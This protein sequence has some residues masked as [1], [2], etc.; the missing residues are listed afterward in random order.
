MLLEKNNNFQGYIVSSLIKAGDYAESYRVKDSTG[1]NYFLKIVDFR[2]IHPSQLD[3]EG[4]LVEEY[5]SKS[6]N[7]K[8]LSTYKE[9]GSIFINDTQHTYIIYEYIIGETLAEKVTRAQRCSVYD[10]KRYAL[11]ILEG[12]KYLHSQDIPIIHN[13]I[14]IQNTMLNLN[15]EPDYAMLIDFGHARMLKSGMRLA[16]WDDLNPFYLAPERF[17][18]ICSVSTDLYSVGVLMYHLLFGRTPWYFDISRYDTEDEVVNE[19]LRRKKHPFKMPETKDFF[20]FDEQ[21]TNIIVRATSN[22]INE[23]FQTATEFIDAI[24]G[25]IEVSRP[26]SIVESIV[27][28][29]TGRNIKKGNGFKDVAGMQ[30]LKDQLKSDVID[31]LNHPDEAKALGINLPNG[32]LFYGPPGCGKTFFAEKFAEE[33]GMNYIYVKCSDVASPYIHGGQ[34][35]I[36]ALFD[37]AREK[38]PT[39]IFLDEID[40]MI[41]DRSK[42]N[43]ASEAGEVN[44][45]LTQLN[46]CGKDKVLVIGATNKPSELDEAALRSGRL[47]LKYYISQPDFETRKKIFEISLS[48]RKTEIG[49]DYDKLASLT[50]NYISA[51]IQLIIDQ[52][53]RVTFKNKGSYITMDVLCDT[54]KVTKPTV[55]LEQIKKHEAIRDAFMNNSKR[56]SRPKIGFT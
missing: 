44:E 43:N 27:S 56:N 26:K 45:F 38:A 50:E 17:N 16:K 30:E 22:N 10:C 19:I 46:N 31:I 24:N 36:A 1:K 5:I 12:L 25:E 8:N 15:A 11:D 13:E 39:I 28:S 29:K 42:H 20:E 48:K 37:E 14:T 21:L 52:A 49:I 54:I 23:R 18:G 40:S 51:D 47:E 32:L 34:Q 9:S 55:T 4:L 53:A 2:K 7:H 3:P 35:K 41:K 33:A 6:V